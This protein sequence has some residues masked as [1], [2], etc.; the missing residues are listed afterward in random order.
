MN[1]CCN[2]IFL[3]TLACQIAECMTDDE[4]TLLAADLVV[5]SDLLNDIVVRREI[6]GKREETEI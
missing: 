3:A 1:P 4:I 2:V 6:C 5:L